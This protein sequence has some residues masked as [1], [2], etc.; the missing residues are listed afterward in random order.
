MKEA[1]FALDKDSQ[2][3]SDGHTTLFYQLCWEVVANDLMVAVED[4][5][6]GVCQPKV[7]LVH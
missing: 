7:S 5:F 6:K 3:G 1:I 2:V 4:Y